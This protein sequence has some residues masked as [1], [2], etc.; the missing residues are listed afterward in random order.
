MSHYWKG[1]F[2][3]PGFHFSLDYISTTASRV[4]VNTFA[5]I[6]CWGSQVTFFFG[7]AQATHQLLQRDG[8][9]VAD[10]TVLHKLLHALLWLGFLAQKAFEGFDLL[11]P[12]VPAWVFV[13]LAEIPVDHPFLQGVVGIRLGHPEG[14]INGSVRR[15]GAGFS[16]ADNLT[17]FAGSI[18]GRETIN[19]LNVV[20][21]SGGCRV[22]DSVHHVC[23]QR[24]KNARQELCFLCPGTAWKIN[25]RHPN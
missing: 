16:I 6:S 15:C 1:S 25:H 3:H 10:V 24:V 20:I 7:H 2:I 17:L 13:Q 22:C 4:Q 5:Q 23:R 11:L 9:V 12:N 8:L 21:P 18:G 14:H 19:P